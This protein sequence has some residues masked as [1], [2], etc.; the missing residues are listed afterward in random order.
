M[1]SGGGE[2]NKSKKTSGEIYSGV[3]FDFSKSSCPEDKVDRKNFSM[4]A[5]LE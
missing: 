2:K 4:E 1:F 5:Q 3:V